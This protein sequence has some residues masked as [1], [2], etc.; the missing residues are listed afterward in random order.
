[1]PIDGPPV[2][3]GALT[4]ARAVPGHD[5]V[6]FTSESTGAAYRVDFPDGVA[7][8]PVVVADDASTL[9][10]PLNGIPGAVDGRNEGVSAVLTIDVSGQM[11]GAPVTMSRPPIG[12]YWEAVFSPDDQFVVYVESTDVFEDDHLLLVDVDA[13]GDAIEVIADSRD[14]QF[15]APE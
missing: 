13:P 12:G 1:M 5:A 6:V 8:D 3:N 4:R 9:P 7:M 11:P 2:D 15:V 14:W 10:Y